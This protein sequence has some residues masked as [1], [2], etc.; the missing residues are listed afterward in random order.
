[1]DEVEEVLEQRGNDYGDY[2]EMAEVAQ[3]LKRVLARGGATKVSMV[4]Q[5][6]L[7]F[8]CTKMARIVCGNPNK[9]D[10]WTDISGYAKLP[11]RYL[12]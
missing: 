6:S 4:Q 5:E 10:S 1:M 8:I 3:Q 9:A 2:K 7:D 11:L 12:P